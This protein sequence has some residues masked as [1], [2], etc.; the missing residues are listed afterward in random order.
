MI[1]IEKYDFAFEQYIK[2]AKQH[3]GVLDVIQCGKVNNPG[4]SDIDVLLIIDDWKNFIPSIKLLNPE[5]ISPLFTHGPFLCEKS[6]LSDL[7][8]FTTLRNIHDNNIVSPEISKDDKMIS[9]LIRQTRCF[10]HFLNITLT[11][12]DPLSAT[13]A[14]PGSQIIWGSFGNFKFLRDFFISSR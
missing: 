2:M 10:L 8:L 9:V 5:I 13:M 1:K 6:D 11:I 3:H 12:V 7:Q 4:V 14:L